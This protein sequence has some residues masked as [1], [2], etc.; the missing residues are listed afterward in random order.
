MT[1][2]ASRRLVNQLMLRHSSRNLPLKL[3][4]VPFCQGLPGAMNAVSMPARLSQPSTAS[5]TNSGPLSLRMTRGAPR[6]SQT[7]LSDPSRFGRSD[8]P[9][10]GKSDPVQF[11]KSDPF[12]RALS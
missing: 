9:Q 1:T 8:P 12:G 4:F 3:S 6:M 7:G 2:L 5:E 11:G 10:F